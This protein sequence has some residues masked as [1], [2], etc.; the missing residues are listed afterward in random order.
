MDTTKGAIRC[1]AC[2]CNQFRT[3]SA[4]CRRCGEPYD[5]PSPSEPAK[6][7]PIQPAKRFSP[8]IEETEY[9]RVYVG[10]HIAHMRQTLGWSQKQLAVKMQTPR[11]YVSKV[12]RGRA[13]PSP[14]NLR[15]FTTVFNCSVEYLLPDPNNITQARE[16]AIFS[17]PFLSQIA[18]L[19]PRLSA[20]DRRIIEKAVRAASEGQMTFPAWIEV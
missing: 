1:R 17:D 12:E 15:R 3:A 7:A 14:R 10:E 18:E 20:G 8:W 13:L 4:Q 2:S 16:R 9:V 11:Q 19:V 5:T 6:P